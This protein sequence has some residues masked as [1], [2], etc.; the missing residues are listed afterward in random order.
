MERRGYDFSEVATKKGFGANN[1]DNGGGGGLTSIGWA[2][3]NLRYRRQ[4][5][6]GCGSREQEAK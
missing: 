5:R 2:G 6:G 4:R 3:V 1:G